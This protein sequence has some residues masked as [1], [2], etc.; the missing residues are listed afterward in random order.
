MIRLALA[1]ALAACRGPALPAL[2]SQGGPAWIELE[3]EHFTVWT[4]SSR[5]RGRALIR[6]M[7]HLRQVVSGVGFSG[8]GGP[9][10][11]SLVFALRDEDEV[12]VFVPEQFAAFASPGGAIRQSLI[13]LPADAR[14]DNKPLVTHELVHVI[15]FNAI[16][17][18]PRWFA[19]GLAEFFASVDTNPDRTT[20]S[21]GTPLPHIVA[22]LRYKPP[23]KSA[24]M[25]ACKTNLCTDDMFY[26]TAWAIFAYLANTR[27]KELLRYAARIDEL[28]DGG[29]RQAW[30]EVFP[31][32]STDQLDH[33]VRKW[34]A[35]GKHT[36]WNFKVELKQ[37]PIA[38]RVLRDADVHAARAVMR[39]LWSRDTD[40]PP[41]E[42]A[43]A[44]AADPAH[45][46][47]NLVDVAYKKS[48]S[49]DVAKRVAAAHST[50][51]RAWWLVGFAAGWNTDEGRAAS[52]T[53][54]A[55]LAKQPS[56]WAPTNWCGR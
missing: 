49:L 45:L 55:L 44:L 4:D 43:M 17:N 53:A 2:P 19:E 47:A 21:V 16:K 27:P 46:L 54:C 11:K 41:A 51:W 50:D 20:G 8:G 33:E 9:E 7:E 48:M 10:A 34:L 35:Y 32:L 1:I 24:Q 36:I 39:Q 30:S 38:E 15:S 22:R 14:D 56:P 26:A 42:L 40:P 37:W 52:T 29:D 3:S 23:T 5:S 13:V 25:F 28:P 18:Q 31:D 6:E 12:D